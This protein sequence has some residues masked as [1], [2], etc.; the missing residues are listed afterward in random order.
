[1]NGF[2]FHSLQKLYGMLVAFMFPRFPILLLFLTALDV[3]AHP[4]DSAARL[5]HL[6]PSLHRYIKRQ[7]GQNTTITNST[8]NANTTITTATTVPLA[9]ASDKQ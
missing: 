1:M 4:H 7:A 2:P 3:A 9:L 5:R 6:A 8:S